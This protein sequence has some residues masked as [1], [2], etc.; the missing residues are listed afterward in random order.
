MLAVTAVRVAGAIRDA[1]TWGV[2]VHAPS[3]KFWQ[4]QKKTIF[5]QKTFYFLSP[6]RFPDLP[7]G[8]V[9]WSN[10]YCDIYLSN[11]PNFCPNDELNSTMIW[12]GCLL[13]DSEL[14]ILFAENSQILIEIFVIPSLLTFIYLVALNLLVNNQ[15]NSSLQHIIVTI[16]TNS[17][18]H[19]DITKFWTNT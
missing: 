2:G 4:Y 6:P 9:V 3:T 17:N 5:L 12:V 19:Y 7:P 13:T 16:A 8:Y 10:L 15:L 1:W 14:F 18:L 11:V